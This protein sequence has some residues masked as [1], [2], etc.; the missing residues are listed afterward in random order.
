M[1][2]GKK[3]NLKGSVL[4]T[5]VS[6][7]SIMIIF[8][9]CALAMAAA[10]NKR[11]RKTYSS[12][13][14]TYTARTT[15]D[16]ILAAIGTNKEFSK[17]I[18]ELG[19]GKSMNVLV[20]INDPTM[21]T[22]ENVVI[23]NAGKRVLYDTEKQ[24]WVE[25][26]LFS[27][28][29]EV[30]IGGEKTTIS[31]NVIQDIPDDGEKKNGAPFLTYGGASMT[32]KV[33]GSGGTY[34]GMGEWTGEGG[35]TVQWN[36]ADK[37]LRYYSWNPVGNY[38]SSN[39]FT[40]IEDKKYLTGMNY[41]VTNS[42]A[43]E[44]PFV[45]NGNFSVN[46]NC[47]I[48]YTYQDT[49]T[50]NNGAEIWGDLS[51]QGA[52]AEKFNIYGDSKIKEYIAQ[53]KTGNDF[54]STPY[55]YVDGTIYG[56]KLK[57]GD[58]SGKLPFNVF[59]GKFEFTGNPVKVYADIYCMDKDQTSLLATNATNLYGWANSTVSGTDA[60]NFKSGNLYSLGN[61]KVTGNNQQIDGD[62]VVEGDLIVTGN[63]T[64][65][66]N[67]VVGGICNIQDGA[68]V[69]VTGNFYCG[70]DDDPKLIKVDTNN[71]TFDDA[72]YEKKDTV[73]Y[74][75]TNIG[76]IRSD[77]GG[78]TQTGCKAYMTAEKLAA[79]QAAYGVTGRDFGNQVVDESYALGIYDPWDGFASED[80]KTISKYY[81]KGTNTEVSEDTCYIYA[82]SE[83]TGALKDKRT[84]VELYR[85]SNNGDIYPNRATRDIL[86]GTE[87]FLKIKGV[88]GHVVKY[89]ELSTD[90]VAAMNSITHTNYTGG[91]I[92]GKG[93]P[94]RNI[95]G[96]CTLTGTFTDIVRIVPEEDQEIYVHLKD[97]AFQ[98]SQ[99][100]VD[101]VTTVN[102]DCYIDIDESQGGKVYIVYDGDI[103]S[104][105]DFNNDNDFKNSR[106]IKT[107][108]DWMTQFNF[109]EDTRK[110]T[111]L[112]GKTYTSANIAE[113]K[114]ASNG[115]KITIKENVTLQG[116]FNEQ[117][118]E[119]IVKVPETG[120]LWVTLDSATFSNGSTIY[121]DDTDT[122]ALGKVIFYVKGECGFAGNSKGIIS[123]TLNDV[124]NDT[125]KKVNIFSTSDPDTLSKVYNTLGYD[126][127]P[128]PI[129]E[130]LKI[131]MYAENNAKL[132]LTNM[133]IITAYIRAAK[134]LD[135]NIV[136]ASEQAKIRDSIIYDGL[137][138]ADLPSISNGEGPYSRFAV[139]GLLNVRSCT[140]TNDWNLIYVCPDDPN[141][142]AGVVDAEGKHTYDAVEYMAYAR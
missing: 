62:L 129:L 41:S 17:S 101:G 115:N 120:E 79:A 35:T 90:N 92:I 111:G 59:C 77:W 106:L 14:S 134:T 87:R 33:G 20:D 12:S 1:K 75:C 136:D 113:L 74:L 29:A 64:V 22:V 63:L 24:E 123:M 78:S 66:G 52:N 105:Y 91:L 116:G 15:I 26:N 39:Y 2:T 97:V 102:N 127:T 68:N 57:L 142:T 44:V 58:A 80:V 73:Y 138:F 94:F 55:L 84:N 18:R 99:K 40:S 122:A 54:M 88:A 42:S 13:Q 65:K 82:S 139:I 43:F 104:N 48:L 72:N 121:V 70:S 89:S 110:N 71:K 98:C 30:T 36:D 107:V 8:M 132:N 21:G 32:Q 95:D 34:L 124:F 133:A 83:Y 130:P 85:Q 96:S 137:S 51:F 5:V 38:T 3:R 49:G 131:T 60:A 86:L 6:V 19:D 46:T 50:S 31:S 128:Y 67:L 93:T 135:M 112:E 126:N 69:N 56:D 118:P 11:S 125:S 117:Q 7:L 9:T 53:N 100:T 47:N 103:S 23:K 37:G 76:R 114:D 109:T 108:Y 4:F 25:R 16:S 141:N 10:A 61:V 81:K 45:V 27:I 140:S 119:I 28:T